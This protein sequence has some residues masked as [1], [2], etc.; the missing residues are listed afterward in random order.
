MADTS[1]TKNYLPLLL[2]RVVSGAIYSLHDSM[3]EQEGY[4]SS[5]QCQGVRTEKQD[6]AFTVHFLA[7]SYQWLYTAMFIWNTSCTSAHS[8]SLDHTTLILSI[9]LLPQAP[10]EYVAT[11]VVLLFLPG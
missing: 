3:L 5:L 7:L 9:P 11:T 8:G 4:I 6:K 10:I 2:T 1:Y